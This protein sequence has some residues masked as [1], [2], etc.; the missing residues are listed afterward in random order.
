[1]ATETTHPGASLIPPQPIP[2]CAHVFS[3]RIQELLD[4]QPKD[5]A[6][7]EEAFAGLEGFFDLIAAKLYTQASMLVGEGE[8]SVRLVETAIA[9]ADLARCSNPVEGR[10]NSRS[11]LATAAIDL[12]ETREPGCLEPPRHPELLGSC[13]EGDDLRLAGISGRELEEAIAGPRKECVRVWLE[14]LP[15]VLRTVFVFRAVLGFTTEECV[16]LFSEHAGKHE[17]EWTEP[18]VRVLFRQALCSLATQVL[19]ASVP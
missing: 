11:A 10:K 13:I 6:T 4:G 9:N 19:H 1:M 14:S 7:V 18:A 2:A 12:L 16:Q 8:E 5:E 17:V 15:A 3:S